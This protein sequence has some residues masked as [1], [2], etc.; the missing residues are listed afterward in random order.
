MPESAPSGWLVRLVSQRELRLML[1][2]LALITLLLTLQRGLSGMADGPVLLS[3]LLLW[4]PLLVLLFWR[5]RMARRAWL[6]VHLRP[7]SPWARRLRGGVLMLTGQALL[8]ALLAMA[9]LISLARGVPHS[10]WIVLVLC[11]P[12]WAKAWSGLQTYLGRHASAEFLTVT[13]A[14][15]LVW[16]AAALLLLG[17]ATWGLWR[18]IPDLGELSLVDAVRHYAAGQAADSP[19]L[20][21]LLT[22][23]AALDGA[24]HWLAQHWF[25]GLPGVGLRLVAWMVVLVQEW[26]FVWPCLLLWE[27]LSH[28]VYGH[29]ARPEPGPGVA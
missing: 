9:L 1:G 29:A 20:R 19:V 6:R 28:V 4:L 13:A 27:A 17:L 23:T 11:V 18:P 10:T 24:R 15:V 16:G 8:A 3:A 25:E 2:L 7:E 26:L 14:R 21:F 22:L 5:R 12:F